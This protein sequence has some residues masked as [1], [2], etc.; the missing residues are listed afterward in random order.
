MVRSGKRSNEI[1][2]YN[3]LKAY[4]A[5]IVGTLLG[6]LFLFYFEFRDGDVNVAISALCGVAA[7]AVFY[8][9]KGRI[10]GF[11]ELIFLILGLITV[12]FVYELFIDTLYMYE[13][14]ITTN[15]TNL[16]TYTGSFSVKLRIVFN[17]LLRGMPAV[18]VL[19]IFS[20]IFVDPII[21]EDEKLN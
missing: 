15:W 1:P 13:A 11:K 17:N 20:I 14:G 8:F 3:S 21:S 4:L 5:G 19:F 18:L 7:F 6:A 2:K 9:A 10:T 16:M 12:F